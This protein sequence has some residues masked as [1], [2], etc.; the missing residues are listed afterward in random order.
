MISFNSFA[1]LFSGQGVGAVQQIVIC[2]NN[3]TSAVWDFF[4]YPYKNLLAMFNL[5]VWVSSYECRNFLLLED[6]IMVQLGLY[7][8]VK[9]AIASIVKQTS[10]QLNESRCHHFNFVSP[11]L[12][13][14]FILL[15]GTGLLLLRKVAKE[16][17]WWWDITLEKILGYYQTTLQLAIN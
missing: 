14:I 4:L 7:W 10:P 15:I 9:S 2:S 16:D 6:W 8:D 3:Q 1:C 5:K 17:L 13:S 11:V 12:I